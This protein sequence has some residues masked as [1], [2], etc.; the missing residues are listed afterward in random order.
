MTWQNFKCGLHKHFV[1]ISTATPAILAQLKC[2]IIFY[3]VTFVAYTIQSSKK[4][5]FF[6]KIKILSVFG[7]GD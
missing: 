7:M 5:F 6:L 4:K 3:D 2:G 1:L